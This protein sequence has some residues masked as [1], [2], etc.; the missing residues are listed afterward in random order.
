MPD[1]LKFLNQVWDAARWCSGVVLISHDRRLLQRTNC[2]LW[3]CEGN[4]K[5]I[6]PLGSD[7]SFDK[8]EKRVLR[9]IEARQ[10]AE[11]ARAAQRAEQRRKRK[12]AALR[13]AKVAASRKPKGS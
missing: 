13:Q 5:G 3:L 7:F 2:A 10:Q 4:G 8:Y 9:Q 11:E 12:E 1:A 6:Q